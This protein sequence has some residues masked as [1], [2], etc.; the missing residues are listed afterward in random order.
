[1]GIVDGLAAVGKFHRRGAFA[2]RR[3]AIGNVPDFSNQDNLRLRGI[4]RLDS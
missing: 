3:I 2:N 1:M 4:W